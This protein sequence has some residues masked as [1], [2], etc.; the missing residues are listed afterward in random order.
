MQQARRRCQRR[1]AAVRR[2]RLWPPPLLMML[3]PPAARSQGDRPS[4]PP[5]RLS[6]P[7]G[8][9]PGR[10][11]AG[12]QHGSDQLDAVEADQKSNKSPAIDQRIL[13]FDLYVGFRSRLDSISLALSVLNNL[14]SPKKG[15]KTSDAA[16]T[17]FP[18]QVTALDRLSLS[19]SLSQRSPSNQQWRRREQEHQRQRQRPT[20][21]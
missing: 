12:F 1:D 11:A 13:G 14:L 19:L 6:R 18:P 21:M 9:D 16:P 2:G 20:S 5:R 3:L 10:A 8:G 17:N 7:P 4:I 15:Q